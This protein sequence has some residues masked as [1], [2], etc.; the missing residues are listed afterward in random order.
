MEIFR[1]FSGLNFTTAYVVF[2]TA[3]VASILINF[4][5]VHIYDFHVFSHLC[6][7]IS[8]SKLLM[9]TCINVR[10]FIMVDQLILIIQE[11]SVL[12]VKLVHKYR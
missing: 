6:Q 11:V 7:C 1:L 5:T 9:Y 12:Q 2:I 3:K 8:V 10:S 4:A